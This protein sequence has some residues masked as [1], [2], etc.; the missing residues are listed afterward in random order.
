MVKTHA[1]NYDEGRCA[2]R[3]AIANGVPRWAIIAANDDLKREQ[4]IDSQTGLPIV[5]MSAS[6]ELADWQSAFV[7]GH[8]EEILQ[9]IKLGEIKVDFR[10]LLM[11]FEQ[12]KEAFQQNSLGTLSA[13][14]P[15][16]EDPYGRFALHLQISKSRKN[17]KTV[18][19]KSKPLTWIILSRESETQSRRFYVFEAPVDIAL[20]RNGQVFL[21]KTQCFFLVHDERTTQLLQRYRLR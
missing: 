18:S 10:P 8:N 20:G 1:D 21:I 9:N 11:T 13:D 17:S 15:K 5:V 14:T 6:Q 19:H 7:Q 4:Q 3:K 16:I 2:A 12:V